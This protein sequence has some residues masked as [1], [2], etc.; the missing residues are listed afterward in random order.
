MRLILICFFICF[1]IASC[2]GVN[3]TEVSLANDSSHTGDSIFA[4]IPSKIEFGKLKGIPKEAVDRL[5][6]EYGKYLQ[7]VNASKSVLNLGFDGLLAVKLEAQ[8]EYSQTLVAAYMDDFLKRELTDERIRRYYDENQDQYVDGEF[9]IAHILIKKHDKMSA[10]ELGEI[11]EKANA[12]SVKSEKGVKFEELVLKY[13]EDQSTIEQGGR[14]G[15]FS[16]QSLASEIYSAVATLDIGD[17]SDFV[18]TARGW[19]MFKMLDREM[20]P[21]PFDVVKD[22]VIYELKK[23]LVQ[24]EL[25]RLAAL[26]N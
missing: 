20:K 17:T 13:S 4:F 23:S 26:L 7:Q 24:R 8:R 19:Q 25:E 6:Q 16:S 18:E 14:I 12:I 9:E 11:A 10:A 3:D 5:N 1:F 15:R 22:Q 21:L 2:S